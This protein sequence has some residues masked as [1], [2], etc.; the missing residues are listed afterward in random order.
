MT[1]PITQSKIDDLKNQLDAHRRVSNQS[2]ERT[3]ELVQR[4]KERFLAQAS[5]NQKAIE[6]Q[7]KRVRLLVGVSGF[8]FILLLGLAT[9]TATL[10]SS[11]NRLG[12]NH[13]ELTSQFTSKSA[14]VLKQLKALGREQTLTNKRL[15]RT[16]RNMG[17]SSEKRFKNVVPTDGK[18]QR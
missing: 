3:R 14:D 15:E 4:H 5:I 6:V 16:R 7:G 1:D 8:L 11:L 18:R 17:I 9:Y 2:Q 12:V 10:V 13:E